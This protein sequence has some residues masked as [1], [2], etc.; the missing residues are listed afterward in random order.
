[1]QLQRLERHAH[2][3]PSRPLEVDDEARKQ[4]GEGEVIADTEDL[5]GQSGEVV[6]TIMLESDTY[7]GELH[8]SIIVDTNGELVELDSEAVD[9]DSV[10]IMTKHATTESASPLVST[11]EDEKQIHID[12]TDGITFATCTDRILADVVHI[13]MVLPIVVTLDTYEIFGGIIAGSHDRPLYHCH[14]Q[15]MHVLIWTPTLLDRHICMD[16]PFLMRCMGRI[17]FYGLL[18][19]LRELIIY[20]F[21]P[22]RTLPLR[23]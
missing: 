8:T 2:T 21:D 5:H 15:H 1:M 12:I 7:G 10:E 16:D 11:V 17:D 3:S 13:E 18:L 22:G 4:E 23:G 19:S 9:D 20:I 6:D 14:S